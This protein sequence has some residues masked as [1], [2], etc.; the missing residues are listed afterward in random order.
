MGRIRPKPTPTPP[1]PGPIP[2]PAPDPGPGPEPADP[3]PA[4]ATGPVTAETPTRAIGDVSVDAARRFLAGSLLA[5]A[6]AEIVR[7]AAGWGAMALAFAKKE[8]SLGAD[9]SARE[10]NNPLGLMRRPGDTRRCLPLRGGCL[11]YFRHWSDAFAEYAGRMAAPPYDPSKSLR[12]N[13]L[14]YVGGPRCPGILAAD[15]NG[16]CANGHRWDAGDPDTDL[17]TYVEQT[18]ERINAVKAFDAR[19]GPRPEPEPEPGEPAW[20]PAGWVRHD[21]PGAPRGI[22]LPPDVGFEVVLTPRGRNRPGGRSSLSGSTQHETGNRGVGADALMHSRWQDSGTP[23]HPD[24]YVAVHVYTDDRRVVVKIPL[25]ETGIHS[26]DWR[27]TAHPGNELCV[28]ADRNAERAEWIAA[29]WQATLMVDVLGKTAAEALYPHGNRATGCPAILGPRWSWYEGRVD[30]IAGGA[31]GKVE[32]GPAYAEAHPVPR[33]WDGTDWRRGDGAL[34]VA[35]RRVFAAAEDGVPALQSADPAAPAVRRPLPKGE[36]FEAHYVVRG[37]DGRPWLVSRFGS[38]IPADRC[39]PRLGD[40]E[41]VAPT[42]RPE[43]VGAVPP[44]FP[45]HLIEPDPYAGLSGK[46]APPDSKPV[47]KAAFVAGEGS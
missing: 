17:K 10:T 47:G 38:R 31:G 7:S 15:P 27:N 25:D 29:C 12:H 39:V 21:C 2:P 13:I 42:G 9:G 33:G 43:M 36:G 22:H 41:R 18:V 37:S 24:G 6:A 40:F 19:P 46:P 20:P 1:A 23:G 4:P 44:P 32:P 8:S 35:L 3:S 16:V 28:N 11:L 5:P 14:V 34:F 30:G 45:G 26:G